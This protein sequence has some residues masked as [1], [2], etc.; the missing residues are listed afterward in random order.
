MS[1]VVRFAIHVQGHH[2]AAGAGSRLGS[3]VECKIPFWHKKMA[4]PK[5]QSKM[6]V[7]IKQFTR[8]VVCVALFAL[9]GQRDLRPQ[10]GRQDVRKPA[11]P[12]FA[13]Q[14]PQEK[15]RRRTQR[16]PAHLCRTDWVVLDA[17]GGGPPRSRDH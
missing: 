1:T 10:A 12:A 14:G 16:E 4:G 3:F 2:S 6:W 5:A 9:H 17:A 13:L 8:N 7:A 15:S 11:S